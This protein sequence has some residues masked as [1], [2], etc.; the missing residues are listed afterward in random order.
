MPGETS[1]TMVTTARRALRRMAASSSLA[2]AAMA[3]TG[4]ELSAASADA[5]PDGIYGA[6]Y[7]GNGRDPGGDGRSGY[8]SY[9]R[10]SSNADVAGWL[11]WR[12]F[13]GV[14]R[15]ADVGCASGFVVEVLREL[16]IDAQGCD[17]S[18]Y[19]IEHATPGA[20]GHV[21]VNDLRN[22][23]PWGDGAFDVVTVLETLEH[24]P[25][26]DVAGV[27]AELR[28][29][30]GGYLYATIPSFGPN[31]DAGPDGFYEGKVRPER[32]EHYRSLGPDYDGPVAYEDL[33]RDV[34]GR[35]VEGHLT[36]ASYRW[37]TSRFAEAGFTRRADIEARIYKD[38]SPS[39]IL[40]VA[41]NV[42]VCAVEGADESMGLP[43]D[44]DKTLVELGLH[45]PLLSG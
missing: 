27:V 35:P 45:H 34:E 2:R 7:F 14:R 19:A 23:L 38:I 22:G 5:D 18:R 6:A 44:P 31:N 42:Y 15:A 30:C 26:D 12:N 43:R 11:V 24:I 13:S 9:D 3:R 41:W 8:G 4:H 28:R 40:P 21:V 17:G 16:G 25:P 33:A 36:I 10:Q 20:R 32:L 29:V 37:W 39:P 1:R